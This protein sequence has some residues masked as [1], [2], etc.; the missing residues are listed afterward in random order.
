MNKLNWKSTKVIYLKNLKNFITSKLMIGLY[1][2]SA[3]CSISGSLIINFSFDNYLQLA[4][5]NIK[6]KWFI[7]YCLDLISISLITIIVVY[8]L[9][10]KH[11]QSGL[12]NLEIRSGVS[13][14]NIF[15]LRIAIAVTVLYANLFIQWLISLI[16]L[17]VSSIPNFIIWERFMN[18]FVF[19][20]LYIFF[21][22]SINIILS[23][24]FKQFISGSLAALLSILFATAP[25]YYGIQ[26]RSDYQHF[27]KLKELKQIASANSRLFLGNNFLNFINKN[28]EY[29]FLLNDLSL[30][31]YKGVE[32]AYKGD[33]FVYYSG[34]GS[35]GSAFYYGEW[36]DEIF[37]TNIDYLTK[38]K[39]EGNEYWQI[40]RYPE[41]L[42]F[43]KDLNDFLKTNTLKH[44]DNVSSEYDYLFD[45]RTSAPKNNFSVKKNRLSVFLTDLAETNFQNGKYK[46]L[47]QYLADISD[48]V[49][50][51]NEMNHN[52]GENP[53][54]FML[55][56][57]VL[58]YAYATGSGRFNDLYK[59]HQQ[60]N[61]TMLTYLFWFLGQNMRYAMTYDIDQIQVFE[62]DYS[63]LLSEFKTNLF[64]NPL[65]Q[66]EFMAFGKSYNLNPIDDVWNVNGEFINGIPNYWY[67]VKIPDSIK[68]IDTNQ[69]VKYNLRFQSS[70]CSDVNSCG[71]NESEIGNS[72]IV[73]HQIA[74]IE[75]MHVCYYILSTIIGIGAFFIFR[76]KAII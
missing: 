65:S 36:L 2:L 60:Y 43:A 76:K 62:K 46:K 23:V 7:K 74:S 44:K 64:I 13:L 21:F 31:E 35:N 56:G 53:G 63:S 15:G 55:G 4:F 75:A 1:V 27:T 30:L 25:M 73:L 58:P 10:I 37:Q 12:H 38:S 59:Y 54:V 32:P 11:K 28:N 45:N 17:E 22:L 48:K 68:Q 5:V 66:F 26:F 33:P 16:C 69:Y 41:I 19:Y 57:E 61:H 71:I 67:E 34:W 8:I 9:F 47:F 70:I 14:I 51:Y 49:Q 6:I 24:I 29:D 3:I 39:E 18:V 50:I 72:K 40:N 20:I 52:V 42:N